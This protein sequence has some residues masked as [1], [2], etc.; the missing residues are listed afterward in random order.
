[1]NFFIRSSTVVVDSFCNSEVVEQTFP[2]IQSSKLFPKW[3]RNLPNKIPVEDDNKVPVLYN[4]MKTC[5]GFNRLYSNSFFLPL[6]FDL[7]LITDI[8]GS[9]AYRSSNVIE[10][11]NITSHGQHQYGEV[12]NNF[13]HL[14]IITPWVIDVNKNIDFL[15]FQ[16][17]FNNMEFFDRLFVLPGIVQLKRMH[18][19]NVNFLVHR[20]KQS[21][22]LPA[23]LPLLMITP[24]TE[25]KVIVKTHYDPLKFE[26]LTKKSQDQH[27]FFINSYK[28]VFGIQEKNNKSK[29]PFFFSQ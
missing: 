22:S 25:K 19:P 27:L 21:F 10:G 24:K 12:L 26:R 16:P 9:W 1:M 17:T 14:K 4:T 20:K 5:D 3:W 7:N 15:F 6:W 23:G 2:I 28:K 13:I 18:T 11:F 8:D 29:C